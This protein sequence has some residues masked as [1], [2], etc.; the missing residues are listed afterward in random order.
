MRSAP[1][2]S[3][4]LTSNPHVASMKCR[5]RRKAERVRFI[6]ATVDQAALQGLLDYDASATGRPYRLASLS[7]T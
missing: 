3:E 6:N 2:L 4:R 7:P 1:D 5:C